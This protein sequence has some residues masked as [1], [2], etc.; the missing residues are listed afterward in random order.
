[1]SGSHHHH[2]QR[3]CSDRER[4]Q[5]SYRVALL[6][7]LATG[8][9]LTTTLGYISQTGEIKSIPFSKTDIIRS[10]QVTPLSAYTGAQPISLQIVPTTLGGPIPLTSLDLHAITNP[11]SETFVNYHPFAPYTLTVTNTSGSAALAAD[12]FQVTVVIESPRAYLLR[13]E[14]EGVLIAE[15][16]SRLGFNSASSF[17]SNDE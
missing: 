7:N 11:G 2:H 6:S 17:Q 10:I 3:K 16:I 9:G 12:A 14:P 15:A 13:L 8:V 5:P 4:K 1:M